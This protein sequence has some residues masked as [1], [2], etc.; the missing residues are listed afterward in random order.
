MLYQGVRGLIYYDAQKEIWGQ[1]HVL[2][3]WVI[4]QAVRE[5]DPELIKFEFH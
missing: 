3:S 1:A 5:G 4:F 2:A